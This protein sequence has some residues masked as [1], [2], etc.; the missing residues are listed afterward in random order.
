MTILSVLYNAI[1]T[2][3][4][5]YRYFIRLVLAVSCLLL[6]PLVSMQFT[7]EVNWDLFDFVFM[8][9]LLVG[10]G[11]MYKLAVRTMRN[12][13]Y[14]AAAGIGVVTSV[15]LVWINGAVGIIGDGPVNL[16]YLGVIAV[17]FVGAFIAR[18][19]PAGMA[20]TLFSMAIVQ[21][22]VPVIALIIWGSQISWEPGILYVFGLNAFFVML[23]VV[24]ALL[25]RSTAR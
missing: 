4:S 5:I 1:K 11:M 19:R 20:R 15:L 14:R 22:L 24:S 21:A 10:A 8:W 6:I 3:E 13:T 7:E 2:S 23:F 25:F 18:F 16:M 9:I 12:I 17:G